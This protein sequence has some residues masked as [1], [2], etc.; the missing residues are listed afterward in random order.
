MRFQEYFEDMDALGVLRPDVVR[1]DGTAARIPS[2]P[3]LKLKV[4]WQGAEKLESERTIPKSREHA[5]ENLDV[6]SIVLELLS[7]LSRCNICFLAP[8]ISACSACFAEDS[9]HRVHGWP[10]AEIRREA[11]REPQKT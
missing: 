5:I 11:G 8:G 10:R 3:G 6:P 7:N 2:Q 9:D 1:L 4:G